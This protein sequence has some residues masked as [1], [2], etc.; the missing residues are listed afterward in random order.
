M[1]KGFFNIL[2]VLVLALCVLSIVQRKRYLEVKKQR[3]ALKQEVVELTEQL[4]RLKSAAENSTLPNFDYWLSRNPDLRREMNGYI[5]RGLRPDEGARKGFRVV[6]VSDIPSPTESPYEHC[7]VGVVLQPVEDTT[8]KGGLVESKDEE[9]VVGLTWGFRDRVFEMIEGV[10]SNDMINTGLIPEEEMH[11][12]IRSLQ[13]IDDTGYPLADRFFLV[14]PQALGTQA[15]RQVSIPQSNAKIENREEV[16]R[17]LRNH[18]V[19]SGNFTMPALQE[20]FESSRAYRN[21]LQSL[22]DQQGASLNHENRIYFYSVKP[23]DL[24]PDPEYPE[25]QVRVITRLRDL[26]AERNIDLIVAPVPTK[27]VVNGSFFLKDVPDDVMLSPYR[28][29]LF[30]RLVEENVE[31]VD[32]LPELV[33]A[34]SEYPHV[35][36]DAKDAH[37]ADGAIQV[38]AREVGRRLL[39]YGL[40]VEETRAWIS[41]TR[42]RASGRYFESRSSEGFPYVATRVFKTDMS[43]LP[44]YAGNKSP[45]LVFSDSFGGVPSHYNV[46]SAS[47]M[48]HLYRE[49]GVLPQKVQRNMGGPRVLSHFAQIKDPVFEKK[50]VCVFLFGEFYIAFADGTNARWVVP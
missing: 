20:R 27:E 11:A 47:V 30:R 44:E 49:V 37:P 42:Y 35:F 28:D 14:N 5:F 9:A 33:A 8:W 48:A 34:R 36:Y 26:L 7:L 45:I 39:R 21:E 18:Y 50:K 10:M 41:Q 22:L 16:M 40:P 31:F 13:T 23:L 1:K 6:K 17:R 38:I 32:L 24:I 19:G 12:S 2:T 46:W 25:P 4:G 3:I 29:L 15:P 43:P